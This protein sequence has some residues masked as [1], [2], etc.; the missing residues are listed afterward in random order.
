MRLSELVQICGDTDPEVGILEDDPSA[1]WKILPLEERIPPHVFLKD[2]S[3]VL[4]LRASTV[5]PPI[6]QGPDPVI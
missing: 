3:T 5:A 1:D 4:V 6:A 2:G